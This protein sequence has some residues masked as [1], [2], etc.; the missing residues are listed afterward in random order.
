MKKFITIALFLISIQGIAQD[1]LIIG[2]SERIIQSLDLS[3]PELD[4]LILVMDGTNVN[5]CKP[6][7]VYFD[8]EKKKIAYRS[9]TFGDSCSTFN[10]WTN[11]LLKKRVNYIM[12]DGAPVWWSEELY[13]SNGQ[14]IFKGPSPNQPGRK[15]YVNYY[16]NGFKKNEFYHLGL[17]VDGKMTWWY[18][19]GVIESESFYDKN[20]PIGLWKYYDD[21][22]KLIKTEKYENGEVI[23]QEVF[24]N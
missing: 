4:S 23:N 24:N 11:G 17:G 8:K 13:C 1:T 20:I 14:L 15:L 7:V 16:C 18:E 12:I 21:S 19:N 2:E 6:V 10:Y 22:G 3:Y 9:E 5:Y